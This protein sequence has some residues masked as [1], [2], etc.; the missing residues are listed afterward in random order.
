MT[1]ENLYKVLCEI[2]KP[3]EYYIRCQLDAFFN[4]NICIHK[5]TNR[6]EYADVLHEW[7]EG[8]ADILITGNYNGIGFN[9]HPIKDSMLGQQLKAFHFT[10]KPSE[11]TFEWQ[12][13][14][15]KV[16]YDVGFYTDEE[17][18]RWSTQATKIEETKRIRV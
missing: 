16:V 2:L 14:Y 13:M 12:W 3:N 7:I 1:K 15:N 6:H 18:S 11:P 5:G 4:S 10:I 17:A 8:N 9:S